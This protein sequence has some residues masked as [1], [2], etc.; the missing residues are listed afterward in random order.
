MHSLY[1]LNVH[2]PFKVGMVLTWI[3]IEIFH[4]GGMG[5]GNNMGKGSSMRSDGNTNNNVCQPMRP[6]SSRLCLYTGR[7]HGS[8]NNQPSVMGESTY[9]E[10]KS[11]VTTLG[12]SAASGH[13]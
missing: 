10:I 6:L 12:A 9:V 13:R 3:R 11:N 1:T 8:W 2:P 5:S 7:S 4:K